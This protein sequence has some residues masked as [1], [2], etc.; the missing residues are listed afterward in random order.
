[1]CNLGSQK[2]Q[3]IEREIGHTHTHTIESDKDQE[4]ETVTSSLTRESSSAAEKCKEGYRGQYLPKLKEQKEPRQIKM[5]GKGVAG[6]TTAR[7]N[8]SKI[9]TRP[10]NSCGCITRING[11]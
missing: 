2:A 5:T 11:K 3:N 8:N 6:E 10:C 4:R 7:P 1:M 9:L